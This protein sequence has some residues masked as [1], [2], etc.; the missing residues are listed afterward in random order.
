MDTL[1]DAATEFDVQGL[2]LDWAVV[3]W[4]ADLRYVAGEWQMHS[5]RG[6]AWQNVVS[7]D[8]RLYLKNA[9]RVILTRARQGM[10]LF[11]PVGSQLDHTRPA[12]YYD[13]TA[14]YLMRC[15]L[16]AV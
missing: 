5:F 2:E 11:V 13:Q 9:Y 3:G 1:E 8:R 15:G 16:P 10:A 7:S 4:D 6:T 12:S 14:E